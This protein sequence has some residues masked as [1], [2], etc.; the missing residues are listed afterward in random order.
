MTW[1]RRLVTQSVLGDW[2]LGYSMLGAPA[3]IG[4]V[5]LAVGSCDTL[6]STGGLTTEAGPEPDCSAD[7]D[8]ELGEI[9][10]L[11]TCVPGCREDDDRCPSGEIC[12]GGECHALPDS[13]LDAQSDADASGPVECPHDM[14][15]V[16]D[17]FCMDRYEASRPDATDV[18]PGQDNSMATSRLNVLPWY[19][20]TKSTAAGACA[21]AGKRLCKPDE[22]QTTCSG[23]GGTVYSYGNSYDPLICNSIDTY[24]LCGSGS[25][26]ESVSPCPYPHCYNAPPAG[27]TEPEGGCGSW[28]VVRPTGSFDQCLS[29]YG[30]VDINGNVWE[31]VDDGSETGQFRGGAFNCVDSELLHRC[32]TIAYTILA[33][34]F[35]CCR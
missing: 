6:V 17:A 35:R 13:G 22:F 4:V 31:L 11:G 30:A 27:Q 34:G 8:C 15:K 16:N 12:V 5:L 28:M 19:P 9:C 2:A 26:C 14:V 18:S 23:T 21:L 32:D 25:P 29:D 3:L 33:K 1:A 10:S 20:V 7:E 24:C